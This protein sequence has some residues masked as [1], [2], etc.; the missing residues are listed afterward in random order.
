VEARSGETDKIARRRSKIREFDTGGQ[1]G[2]GR[3]KNVSAL[4]GRARFLKLVFRFGQLDRLRRAI[5]LDQ[6]TK[7]AVVGADAN[8]LF[9]GGGQGSAG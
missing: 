6:I 3:C 7:Q 8:P 4:E 2:G 5:S 9:P 1:V